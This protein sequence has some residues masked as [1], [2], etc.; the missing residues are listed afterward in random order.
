MGI[1]LTACIQIYVALLTTEGGT[2]L[3]N[4]CPARVGI[5]SSR[6]ESEK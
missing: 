2:R 1:G 4:Q 3:L 6:S 5:E